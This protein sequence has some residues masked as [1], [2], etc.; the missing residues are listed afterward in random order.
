M[1]VSIKITVTRFLNNFVKI[2]DPVIY[3]LQ[4]SRIF[5]LK[6][7]CVAVFYFLSIFIDVLL[8]H[9]CLFFEKIKMICNS[10]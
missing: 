10:A 2:A 7:H 4:K 6:L 5:N 1:L 3:N 8:F 9:Y